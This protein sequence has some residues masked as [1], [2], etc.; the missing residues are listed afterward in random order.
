MAGAGVH[1]K[2]DGLAVDF[3]LHMKMP[4]AL[5]RNDQVAGAERIGLE[6]GLAVLLDALKHQI[7]H[8]GHSQPHG[9]DGQGA[10]A[11]GFLDGGRW[12]DRQY[13]AAPDSGIQ[14]R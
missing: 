8:P 3:A 2:R 12:H 14:R 6:A 11:G 4:V 7:Q 9:G 10:E 13:S 1:Q 5:A